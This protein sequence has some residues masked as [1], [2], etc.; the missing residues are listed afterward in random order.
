M[1]LVR[2]FTFRLLAVLALRFEPR[3]NSVF[4]RVMPRKR[5]FLARVRFRA[6]FRL[7][8]SVCFSVGAKR[9]CLAELKGM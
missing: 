6:V 3:D 9:Y 5:C 8:T 1:V 7:R 2:Y 4:C